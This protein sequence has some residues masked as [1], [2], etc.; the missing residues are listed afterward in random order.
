MEKVIENQQEDSML[1]MKPPLD[2]PLEY[3]WL[4]LTVARLCRSIIEVL[5]TWFCAP[6]LWNL[7]PEETT[8]SGDAIMTTEKGWIR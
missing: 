6:I 1:M 3:A 5:N 7:L 4:V 8:L 2:H